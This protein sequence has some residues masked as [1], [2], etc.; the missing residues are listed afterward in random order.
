MD[1]SRF[2]RKKIQRPGDGLCLMSPK[3]R[4]PK[5]CKASV[6]LVYSKVPFAST[7]IR[8][9]SSASNVGSS[10][11]LRMVMEP[12]YLAEEVIIHPNHHLRR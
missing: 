2:Q 5:S 11:L 6:I 7:M 12:K 4:D 3:K 9:L 8:F 10:H 1:S